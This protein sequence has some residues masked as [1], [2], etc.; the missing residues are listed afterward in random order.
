[1]M[2]RS[3]AVIRFVMMVGFLLEIEIESS[4]GEIKSIQYIISLSSRFFNGELQLLNMFG[5]LHKLS[6]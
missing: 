5:G 3:K 6:S 2:L 1:M 4:R